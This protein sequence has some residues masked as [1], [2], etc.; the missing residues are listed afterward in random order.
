VSATDLL[1]LRDI[2]QPDSMFGE[3]SPLALAP[4][5]RSVA[6]VLTQADPSANGYC[7]GLVLVDLTG[8]H[9]ARMLDQGGT[10]ITETA[11]YRGYLVKGGFPALIVPAWSPDGRWL[12]YLRRDAGVSQIW[13][14]AADGSGAHPITHSPVDVDDWA[15]RKDGNSL[16]Y[17]ARPGLLDV[18][19]QIDSKGH[20]GWLYDASISPD[21][22]A[23]PQIPANV[24]REIFTVDVA[25]AIVD[26]ADAQE[27]AMLAL[28]GQAG[29][30]MA[31]ETTSSRGDR[32]MVRPRSA[33]PFAPTDIVVIRSGSPDIRCSDDPCSHGVQ[34]MWWDRAGVGL[35]ILKRE[36]WRDERMALYRWMPR[37]SSPRRL[38]ATSDTLFGCQMLAAGLLCLSENATMPRRIVLI[39]PRSGKAVTV[40]DPNPEVANWKIGAVRRLRWKNDQGLEAWGDLVLP[41]DYHKGTKIPLVFVQ[42]HSNGFLRGGTGDEYPIYPLAAH[43]MA[44]LSFERPGFFA[45]NDPRFSSWDQIIAAG[46]QNWAER[47]SLLSAITRGID[48]AVATGSI[49]PTRLGIT[50]LSD[51]ASSTRFALLNTA[52]FKAASISTCCLDPK[53]VMTYGGIAWADYN[54]LLGYPLATRDDPA[55]WKPYSLALGASTMNTPLLMQVA[56]SELLLALEA[57]E[58]LREFNK[59]VEMFVFPNEF[60]IK[61]QPSHRLSIYQRNIDWFDFWLRDKI[62]RDPKKTEQHGRWD[63]LRAKLTTSL[64]SRSIR[65]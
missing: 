22:G 65:K 64:R 38:F 24:D 55:F 2:G 29:E 59:P 46:Q 19:R 32:A 14:A 25:T 10:L 61:W 41:P 56:D 7:R 4:D 21:Y 60:H 42:Y 12:A 17:A 40:F 5:Q 16:V 43:G 39:N 57:H 15:W 6:F 18:G 35:F 11:P 34:N 9:Q 62:D 49:D 33:S 36:G 47:R 50:G 3:P 30:F 1:M 45:A 52:I 44:V 48:M 63:A 58:A 37:T 23:R 8:S 27:R 13:R 28:A 54:A 31:S 53:T 26:R 51:G 20:S